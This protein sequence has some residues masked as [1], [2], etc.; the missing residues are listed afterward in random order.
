M[1]DEYLPR[2]LSL[3][4]VADILSKNT[5]TVRRMVYRGELQVVRV[6]GTLRFDPRAV[7]ANL[8]KYCGWT[9]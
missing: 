2:F 8:I 3:D 5:K 6:N 4:D 9:P 1:S 7:G